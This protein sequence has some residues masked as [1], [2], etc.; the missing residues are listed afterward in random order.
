MG[1]TAVGTLAKR[2]ELGGDYKLYTITATVASYSD[3]ITLTQATHGI[4][5]IAG[6]VGCHAVTGLDDH[7]TFLQCSYSGLDITVY[8]LE[9]DGTVATDFTTTTITLTVLGKSE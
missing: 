3:T 8:S 4:S 6:I 2:T 1:T 5:E 9:A 7:F